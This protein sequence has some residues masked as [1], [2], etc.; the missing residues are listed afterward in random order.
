VLGGP[1]GLDAGED[2]AVLLAGRAARIAASGF[3]TT[4]GL[5][6]AT[7][8]RLSIAARG[9]ATAAGFADRSAAMLGGEAGLQAREEAAPLRRTTRIATSRLAAAA[10]LDVAAARL[11]GA[12]TTAH[13]PGMSVGC[14]RQRHSDAQRRQ[15]VTFHREAPE[16]TGGE[17]HVAPWR[18]R[19]VSPAPH[20]G[21]MA[22]NA[23]RTRGSR[24]T[25]P[26]THVSYQ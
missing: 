18:L 24:F 4:R 20:L 26:K 11:G 17:M 6:S 15:Q 19:R 10:W 3:A 23:N 25:R 16:N 14:K 22:P 13:A 5:S 2:A 12:S 8:G 9:F 1:T 21:G 7:A